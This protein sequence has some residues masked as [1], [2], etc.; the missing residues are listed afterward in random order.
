MLPS[1]DFIFWLVG[2]NFNPP[3]PH[4]QKTKLKNILGHECIELY[5]VEKIKLLREGGTKFRTLK[6]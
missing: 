4:T 6:P 1:Q 2:L 3:H 5:R